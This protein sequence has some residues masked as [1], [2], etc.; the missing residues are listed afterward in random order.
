M[1]DPDTFIRDTVA[2]DAAGPDAANPKAVSPGAANPGAAS[3]VL[4][5]RWPGS[6]YDSLGGL[7]E[8]MAQALETLGYNVVVFSAA[9]KE[10]P[11]ELIRILNQGGISFALTMSGIGIDLPVDGKLIWEAAKI[12]V[13]NWSCDHPCYFPQ[14]HG[15]RNPY[16]LH[17]YVF[18]DHARYNIRHLSPNGAAFSVHIGIPPRTLFPHAPLPPA[19]RNGRIMFAKSGM[20]INRIEVAWRGYA[21]ILQQVAFAAAEELFGRST[22]D[23]FPVVQRIAELH[24]LMLDG[25]SRLTMR[26]IREVDEYVRYKRADLVMNSIMRYPVDVFGSGWDHI[27]KRGG[28]AQVNGARFH[29][30]VNWRETLDRLPHY[31]GCLSTNPL[32]EDSVHDRVF[33]ALA[34]G[35]VP[36]SDGNMFSRTYM[37]ALE[38]YCF[39]FKRGRIEQAVEAVLANPGEAIERTEDVWRVLAAPFAMQRS[40]WQIVQFASMYTLNMTCS[41]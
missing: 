38:P 9:Q 21:T 19:G 18:P 29:G 35:V 4:I 7:L 2:A 12:P 20:D 23:F 11:H 6:A 16:V 5:L 13:F 26:L 27:D 36:V 39:D 32:V 17:G 30:A 15:I 8:L 28:A 34:A 37:P 14:R 3:K 10:W 41:I 22:A 33:F 1:A 25:N 24:G 31:I 40:A